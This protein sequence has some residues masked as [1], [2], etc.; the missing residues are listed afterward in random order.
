MGHWKWLFVRVRQYGAA[1]I[2]F[3]SLYLVATSQYQH[4]V[5]PRCHLHSLRRCF[6]L[7]YLASFLLSWILAK[8]PGFPLSVE[9]EIGGSS[10]SHGGDISIERE[11]VRAEA[12]VLGFAFRVAQTSLLRTP[13]VEDSSLCGCSEETAEAGVQ[14]I[15]WRALTKLH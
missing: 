6:Q 1:E 5:H 9:E 2:G 11:R 4:M 8:Y 15:Q 7:H 10:E 3:V 12:S 14:H 13:G